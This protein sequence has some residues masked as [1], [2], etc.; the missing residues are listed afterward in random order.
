MFSSRLYS[1]TCSAC[2][3]LEGHTNSVYFSSEVLDTIYPEILVVIKFG[4][5][6]EIWHNALLAEFKCGGLPE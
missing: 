2:K 6:P 4:D 5:L 3:Y 1:Q